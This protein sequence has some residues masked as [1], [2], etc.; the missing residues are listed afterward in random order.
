[1][2]E[3]KEIVGERVRTRRKAQA[4]TVVAL[5][6]KSGLSARYIVSAEKGQ[7]NLSLTKLEQLCNALNLSLS[8]LVSRQTR[9]EID[10]LLA[11]RTSDELVEIA[12]WLRQKY[13]Q[14]KK[15]LV[16]LLG[17]RGAGKTAVGQRLAAEL[18]L[19]FE[20]LDQRIER[21][22]ELDLAEIFELHGEQFYRRLEYAALNAMVEEGERRVIATGGGVVTDPQNFGRLK[23]AGVTIWLKATAEEHWNRVIDQ[24]DNRP[25]RDH[26]QA[27][28]ELRQLMDTREPLY[29]QADHT[30]PT[31][32][33]S[34]GE[35]VDEIRQIFGEC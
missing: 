2:R 17:V 1:M 7:A 29:G 5:A 12:G 25:M 23:S 28:A 20:E 9:G 10:G 31:T 13:S 11:G 14:S 21:M 4:M 24:G 32:G 6:A 27:M 22:A 26:P 15:P 16:A 33:R 30:I 8:A 18:N 35:I 3:I 19:P 34:I